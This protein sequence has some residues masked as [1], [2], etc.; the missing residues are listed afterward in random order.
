MKIRLNASNYD[1]AFRFGISESSV[2]CVFSKWIE[3]MDIYIR[4]S[5]L[6]LWPDTNNIQR[7]MPFCFQRNYG[8]RVISIIN[9][10]ELFIEKPSD[11][12]AKSYM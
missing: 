11:L 2:C 1:L 9:C 8:L 3:A 5:F 4:L 6:I 7:T 10:F 12:L